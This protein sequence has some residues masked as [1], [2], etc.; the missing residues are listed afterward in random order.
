MENKT[1]NNTINT[2]GDNNKKGIIVRQRSNKGIITLFVMLIIIIVGLALT[3]PFHYILSEGMMFPKNNLTFSYTFITVSDIDNLIERY[4]NANSLEKLA[5]NNEPIIRKLLEKGIICD[6]QISEETT[7]E[8]SEEKKD[9]SPESN[10]TIEDSGTFTDSRD[11]KIYKTIRIGTQTWMAE[12]LAYNAK[13]GCCA[14]EN[15]EKNVAKSGYFYEWE[16]AKVVC[17]KGWHMPTDAEWTTLTNYLGGE[18]VA[19]GK[20]KECGTSH[21]F[22][23]N[24]G[25]T[26]SSGFTAQ[27]WGYRGS[28]FTFSSLNASGGWW[29]ATETK[30]NGDFAWIRT[31]HYDNGKI[32][33]SND[34][35]Y[36]AYN[37]RCVRD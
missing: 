36:Y 23:P 12:N 9:T 37:V 10:T 1:E 13:N 18:S 5:M 6:K 34:V 4:N 24:S 33:R 15:N 2:T 16:T 19:G 7:N 11:G 21:W 30:Q 29:S 26:N 35:T 28:N 31:V 14:W 22:G 3:L 27:G 25:A 17:P 8:E 32:N 20:L